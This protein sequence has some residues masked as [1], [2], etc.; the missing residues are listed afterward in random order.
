MEELIKVISLI[1]EHEDG[2][3]WFAL[4]DPETPARLFSFIE[5]NCEEGQ[6]YT[7]K[8]EDVSKNDF[9]KQED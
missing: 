9:D 4:S 7:F 6:E 1:G 2:N 5:S 3:L 8:I